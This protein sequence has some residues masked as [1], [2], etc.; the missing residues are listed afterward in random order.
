[1]WGT[2]LL[3]PAQLH[4]YHAVCFGV[5]TRVRG[6]GLVQRRVV[7]SCRTFGCTC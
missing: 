1:M 2:A 7:Q 6:I 3:L 4:T 5:P